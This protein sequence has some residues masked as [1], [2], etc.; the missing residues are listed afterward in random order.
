[1][2]SV[3]TQQKSIFYPP[4]GILIWIVIYV[5]LL[6][7][8]MAIAALA[9]YGSQERVLFHQHSQLLNK[10]IAAINT[11]FLLTGGYF[12]ARAVYYFK[13]GL[14]AKTNRFF[15]WAIIS[16][17]AFLVLKIV[18]YHQKLEAGLTMNYSSFFMNYWLLTAF[19]WLHVLVG[20]VILFF[21]R[22]G[23]QQ[24]KEKASLDD[25]EAGTAFWHMCD[26]IWLLLF[27]I[28]YLL[29]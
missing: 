19:H 16:G 28:L 6:T 14:Y 5:E 21:I 15:G 18:E 9:Y 13:A 24:K 3:S 8:G 10:T 27:P 12:A 29:F 11:V 25:I 7:F 20:V 23:I 4:G 17:L 1:M 2:D 26:L 22:R